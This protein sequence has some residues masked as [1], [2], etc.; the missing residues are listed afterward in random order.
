MD[1]ELLNKYLSG[2]A[3]TEEKKQVI[4]WVKSD[5]AHKTKLLSMRKLYDISLWQIEESEL[6]GNLRTFWSIE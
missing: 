2:N 4:A 1:Q 3:S 6:S 5:T